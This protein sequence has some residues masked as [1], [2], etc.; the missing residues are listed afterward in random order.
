MTKRSL[1]S[2]PIS[3]IAS[4]LRSRRD[5]L[6]AELAQLDA[7][8]GGGSAPMIVRAADASRRTASLP[9]PKSFRPRRRS[10]PRAGN[11]MTLADAMT[12]VIGSGRKSVAEIVA[13]IPLT[14]YQSRSEDFHKVVGV[15]LAQNRKRFKRVGR[16]VYA[17][18]K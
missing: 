1:S 8:L 11:T 5:A 2:V 15:N 13:G 7:L 14:G 6:A 4:E 17:V 16:G 9:T 10:G 3:A 12:M 18:K